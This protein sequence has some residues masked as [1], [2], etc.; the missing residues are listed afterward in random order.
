[1]L[2]EWAQLVVL[3]VRVRWRRLVEYFQSV[4]RYYPNSMFR[5]VDLA[6]LYNYLFVNPYSVARQFA[7][8]NAEVDVYTY[9]ETPLTTLEII[10]QRAGITAEDTVYELGCGRGR[11]CFWLRAFVGCRVVGIEYNPVFVRK[12]SALV[13]ACK[14]EG[15]VFRCEDML[16]VDYSD[17]TVVYL[18]GSCLEDSFLER[19]TEQLKQLPNGAKVITVSYALQ[20]Y[21]SE[22]LFEQLACWELPFTWGSASVY[23]Q[24]RI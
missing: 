20:D 16:T 3:A 15:V 10:A 6:L 2:K 17:A 22:A 14:L 18:Y 4:W 8:Y 7:I 5:R 12:A 19:L 11:S 21:C 13:Q 1:M 9:G 23:Y 24:V